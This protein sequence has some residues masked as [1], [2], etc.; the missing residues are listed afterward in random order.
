[1]CHMN[2]ISISSMHPTMQLIRQV[3]A[4]LLAR[5]GWS[6]IRRFQA[7]TMELLMASTISQVQTVTACLFPLEILKHTLQK[8]RPLR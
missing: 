8:L 3:P 5:Q 2:P 4:G 1:M 6:L 7:V